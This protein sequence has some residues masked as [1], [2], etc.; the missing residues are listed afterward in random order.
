MAGISSRHYTKTHSLCSAARRKVK[1]G[2][3]GSGSRC[4]FSRFLPTL[5]HYYYLL[6]I[7]RMDLFVT[8]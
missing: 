1:K 7:I 4:S 6:S 3:I 5:L 8:S 2:S